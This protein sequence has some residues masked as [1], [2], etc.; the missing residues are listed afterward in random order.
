MLYRNIKTSKK[1]K[2]ISVVVNTTNSQDGQKMVLFHPIDNPEMLFV[3]E[4][5]EFGSKFQLIDPAGNPEQSAR[6]EHKN[7][8]ASGPANP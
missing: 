1:Y 2:W 5:F 6:I 7:P 3:R 8:P 4:L